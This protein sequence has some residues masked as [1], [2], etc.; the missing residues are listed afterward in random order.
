MTN[1]S[2]PQRER[3]QFNPLNL[4]RFDRTSLRLLT[5]T[6]GPKSQII[7]GGYGNDTYNNWFK[8]TLL[9]EAC[10]IIIKAGTKLATSNV[11]STNRFN[12]TTTRFDVGFYD[13]NQNPIEPRIIHQEP[14]VYKGDVAGA[15]SDLYNT[16]DPN[17]F[18]KGNELFF[19]LVPGDYMFCVSAMRNELF[20][21]GVGLVL[22]FA[23]NEENFILT[24]DFVVAYVLQEDFGDSS[25]GFLEIPQ[26]VTQ[27]VTL[28]GLSAYTPGFSE[29]VSGVF[30][31]VNF[32]NPDTL[33]PLTW[34]IGPDLE[35]PS[36]G[37]K[38]NLDAT[39]NW[40]RTIPP[41]H[42]LSEWKSAW[43]RDH[44]YDERFPSGIFAPYAT[45]Q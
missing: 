44:S 14:P 27:N 16:Y 4:G 33:S 35:E 5:G 21:Y 25:I 7:Q 11:S 20:N 43:D 2:V 19:D 34:I 28:S 32:E 29:I 18:N 3:S 37:S 24:E 23:E 9:E 39:E 1:P 38:I 8:F 40:Y 36:E 17:A 13:I 22:E 12:E 31:Q 10:V 6:L 42:S 15:Q 30:V 45:S 41:N 26:V